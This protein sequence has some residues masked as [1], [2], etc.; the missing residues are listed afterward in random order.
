[1]GLIYPFKAVFQLMLIEIRVARSYKVRKI[2][3]DSE[4]S[5]SEYNYNVNL[6]LAATWQVE[7]DENGAKREE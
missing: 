7:G 3:L 6:L 1:M 4:K 2:E 5:K